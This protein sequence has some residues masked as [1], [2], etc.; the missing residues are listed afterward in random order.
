[1]IFSA[2]Y[3]CSIAFESAVIISKTMLHSF[4]FHR[5]KILFVCGLIHSHKKKEFIDCNKT[6]QLSIFG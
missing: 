3:I 4:I 1:M 2:Y 6:V 5:I